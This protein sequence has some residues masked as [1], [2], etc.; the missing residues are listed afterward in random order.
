MRAKYTEGYRLT[1]IGYRLLR[2]AIDNR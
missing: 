1:V 2:F